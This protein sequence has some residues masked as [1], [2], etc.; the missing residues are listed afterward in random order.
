MD[1][2]YRF[3]IDV[4]TGANDLEP[5]LGEDLHRDEADPSD[6]RASR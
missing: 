1:E 4:R 6:R 2:R 3:V 5:A